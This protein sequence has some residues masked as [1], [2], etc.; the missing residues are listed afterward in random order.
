MATENDN[1][2]SVDFW[3]KKGSE[4][5]EEEEVREGSGSLKRKLT[6]KAKH[7]AKKTCNCCPSGFHLEDPE[8][9]YKKLLAFLRNR[10]A[11]LKPQDSQEEA[12]F[13]Q[14]IAELWNH[15]P[16]RLEVSDFNSC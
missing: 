1:D 5:P 9:V 13:T 15:K 3:I 10:D 6:P 16:A 8:D 7:P 2:E 4:D 11:W 14:L 12:S